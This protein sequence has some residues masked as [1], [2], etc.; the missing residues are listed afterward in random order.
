MNI[1]YSF[2]QDVSN[3]VDLEYGDPLLI[4]FLVHLLDDGGV[5]ALHARDQQDVG[6][7]AAEDQVLATGK[8]KVQIC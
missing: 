3:S 6:L 5:G 2:S 7:A 1:T 8:Y 4:E